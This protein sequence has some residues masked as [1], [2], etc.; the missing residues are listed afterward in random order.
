MAIERGFALLNGVVLAILID[1]WT[2]SDGDVM[3]CYCNFFVEGSG[4][5]MRTI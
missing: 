4:P 1:V 2:F 3:A 5:P